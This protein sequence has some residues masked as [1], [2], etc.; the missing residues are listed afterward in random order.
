MADEAQRVVG[1]GGIR[2]LL[3]GEKLR[4][5]QVKGIQAEE[6]RKF[7]SVLLS[8]VILVNSAIT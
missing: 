3:N 8:V 2:L 6:M 7:Y 5:R 4:A 1:F